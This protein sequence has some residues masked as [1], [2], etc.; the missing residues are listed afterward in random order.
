M[1]QVCY[2][3]GKQ[4]WPSF[5]VLDES[6]E[7]SQ[8]SSTSK[9]YLTTTTPSSRSTTTWLPHPDSN[10]CGIIKKI[11]SFG[12]YL[13]LSSSPGE[14]PWTVSI[15]RYFNEDEESYYKCAGTIIDK[16]TILTSVNCLLDDGLLLKRDDLKV[17]A[18]PFSLAA[19]MH[20]VNLYS[21]AKVITHFDYN[22]NLENNIAALKLSRDIEFNDYV[23]PICVPEN[24][25]SVLGKIGKV[26]I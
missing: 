24:D 8:E 18:S 1:P 9:E 13:A 14:F 26:L 17:Y 6:F 3:N 19:K 23:Q 7:Q 16:R 21:I 20:R 12:N 2:Q 10:L 5:I 4:S 11:D 22:F 15:Y 25:Y